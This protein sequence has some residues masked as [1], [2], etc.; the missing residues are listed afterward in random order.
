MLLLLLL[1]GVAAVVLNVEV[2]VE[3]EAEACWRRERARDACATWEST[4]ES[5]RSIGAIVCAKRCV[6]RR[7]KDV[8]C[9]SRRSDAANLLV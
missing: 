8:S 6:S 5:D 1:V 4:A 9:P 3:V 7:C 2:E